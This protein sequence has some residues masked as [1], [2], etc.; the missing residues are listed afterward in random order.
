MA[1]PQAAP[2]APDTPQPLHGAPLALGTFAL[3]LATFMNVLDSSIANVSLPAISGDLGVSPNQGVWVITSFAVANAI[4]LPLTGWLTQRIGPV[5]LFTGSVLLF[6][7]LSWMC[8]MAPSIELL[9]LFRVIQ[10]AVAGPMIPLSQTLL[11]QSYPKARAGMALAVWSMTV[12]VAPVMGPLLGGWITDNIAWP[13]IF[14]IN[15]PVGLL[16]A[17]LAWNL[18]RDRE[19]PTKKLPID[20]VGLALLVIWVGALQIML[21]K[22][23]ELDWFHSR[24]I[25]ALAV[26]SAV[27]FAL[28]VIWELTE[29]HPVVDLTLFKGRNFWAGTLS[30]SLGYGVFFGN[31]VMLPLWLQLH[32]GYTATV[33]GWVLAPVGV[34]AILCMPLVGRGVA[35]VDPRWLSTVS[36]A[37]FALVFWMRSRFNTEADIG[38]IVI[39]TVIQGVGSAFLFVPLV[40]M[41][42]SGL[43]P[44]RIAAATGLSNFVRI[45]AGAFG[46]S[47]TT[48]LWDGRSALHHAQ[49]TE[50][51]G[52]GTGVAAADAFARMRALGLGDG[53]IAAYLNQLI[54][55]QAAML[56][57]NDI[58]AGSALLFVLAT[59][60]VWLARP[61]RPEAAAAATHPV[62]SHGPDS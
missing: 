41:I 38:T 34:L 57:A 26:L 39:P 58:F 8:G 37:V 42:L 46:A 30:I 60:F 14:Y 36:F 54:D 18:Y 9:I 40:A 5:R 15:V 33:A 56:G 3:S 49:L 20:V 19:S 1:D 59:G 6:V 44:E 16:A 35:T 48:T 28:F 10:G 52:D 51:I 32:M 45:T 2:P 17:F 29:E 22:G 11:L 7:L 50:R 21:D 62:P 12:L 43:G 25:V 27:G 13:W 61:V 31:I 4:S 24:G 55:R 47:I 53:Q 23:R